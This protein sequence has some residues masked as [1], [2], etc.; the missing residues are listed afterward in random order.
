MIDEY[1][2][3]H[4]SYK[5]ANDVINNKITTGKYIKKEARKFIKE[6][7]NEDSKYFLDLHT[8]RIVDSLTSLLIMADGHKAG[9]TVKDSLAPFQWYFLVNALC[10]KYKDN[11]DKRK[12]E[13][14]VLL[15]ARKSGKSF[16]VSLIFVLLL[17]LEP[18]NSEF[19]SVAPDRELS[20]IVK[21][22]LGKII[23]SS[24]AITDKFKI[25]KSEITCLINNSK[26][27]ALATSDNRLDG[28]KANVYV[29]DEVGALKNRYPIEAME[30]SQLSMLNRTGILISTAYQSTDNP[31][32]QEVEYA[33]KVLD[34][35][36]EDESC[37]ALLY[38]PDNPKEWMTDEALYQANPLCYDVPENYDF[39]VKK[40][41]KAIEM[42]S[43][44]SNFLT[45]HLNIFVD[46]DVSEA[47]MNIDD[48]QPNKIDYFDWRGKE[49]YIGVD[50]SLTTDNTAVSMV[51]YDFEKQK[52]Y[53]K[54]WSFIP[55][56]GV[57]DKI[58][59]ER[60]DYHLMRDS[61]WAYFCGDRVIDYRFVEDFI[62]SLEKKYDV[63]I[64]G[65][66]YDKY[67]AISSMRRISEEAGYEAIEVQQSPLNLHSTFKTIKEHVLKG[68][69]HYE[70]N[71]LLEIHFK[72]ARQV[73]SNNLD[74]YVNKK[75]SSGKID[76]L[77]S[78]ADAV[79]LWHKE[80]EEMGLSN[81]Y[82]KRGLRVL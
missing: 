35:I 74:M 73:E 70:K 51:H 54:S 16:L 38:K 59:K 23:E 8:L 37:F 36:I 21:K 13:K 30:S 67:Q 77:F 45:K 32:T 31:M 24:P 42:T 4:P 11:P 29:A 44:R 5:Y 7:E 10:W 28:R 62:M 25:I 53:T 19:Y 65:I 68:N 27:V 12:Y 69:F 40:R 6:L 3:N 22:E 15:I 41:D 57:A 34:G 55:E 26:M 78:T 9:T 76:M 18:Q 56:D 80:I 75:K 61:G 81:V 58:Q 39:L 63:K 71:D 60:V 17:L 47:Y 64:K 50:L 66:G 20:S 82:A 33:E 79:F 1:L 52:Y 72:N 49:V 14:S 48:L 2:L 43:A 46:G